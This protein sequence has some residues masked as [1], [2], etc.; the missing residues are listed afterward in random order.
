VDPRTGLDDEKREI[1]P[2]PGLDSDP[3]AVQPVASRCTDRAIGTR[4]FKDLRIQAPQGLASVV[5]DVS[6]YLVRQ[7]NSRNQQPRELK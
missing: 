6:V 2:L 5:T 1:S 7:F 4:T 3:S